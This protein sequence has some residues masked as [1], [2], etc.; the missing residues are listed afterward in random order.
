MSTDT[1][2][3]RPERDDARFVARLRAAWTPEP[4]TPARRAE[5]DARL[6]ARLEATRRRLGSWPA[7][8]AA[9]LATAALAALLLVRGAPAPPS[10]PV[11]TPPAPAR[12]EATGAW[13]ADL[14][15]PSDEDDEGGAGDEALPAEYAA[16]AGAFL[17]R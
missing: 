11:A 1:D 9:G 16:I 17:D 10:A 13:A 12:A 7:L 8:G 2:R 15:Y 3:E 14:L 6:Q 5:F 4:L